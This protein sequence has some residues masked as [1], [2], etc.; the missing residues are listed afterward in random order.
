[1]KKEDNNF[2]SKPVKVFHGQ[3]LPE[4]AIP[5]GYLALIHAY[6]LNVPR[7]YIL[8]ATGKFHKEFEGNGWHIL[9]PRY[10]PVP[11]LEGH[12]VFALKYEGLNLAILKRLFETVSSSRIKAIVK[13]KPTG[14]YARRIWFL[15]EWL[16]GRKLG[17][18]D[19][20][21]G[22]YVPAVDP[23][24]QYCLD[25]K[26]SA[27]HRVKNNLPGTPN[28]CPLVFKTERIKKFVS[29]KLSRRAREIINDI[30]A[31]LLARSASFFLLE[32][33]RSS[34]VIEGETPPATRIQRWARVIGE[35][36]KRELDVD[37]LIRLQT[38]LIGDTRFVKE[39]I[40]DKGGF[41]GEHDRRTRRPLPEHISAKAM[42]L[43]DLIK[44][45][46]SFNREAGKELD[47]VISAAVLAFGFLFIHPFEDG[48]GR[49]HRYLIH[50]TLAKREFNPP[51]MIFPISSTILDKIEDY[52]RVLQDYS[53]RLLSAIK[54]ESTSDGNVKVL[55][56]TAD[57]YRFFDCTPQVEFLYKCV[58]KTVKENLPDEIIF[59]KKYDRFC[60]RINRIVDMPD[61][62]LNLLF[63]F[64]RQNEGRLSK[65]ALGKEFS[66]LTQKETRQIED[67]YNEIFNNELF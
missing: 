1:M 10:A 13:K 14:G 54:W 6:N 25:G 24:L 15:Y 41:V 61:R 2:F 52:R 21:R 49:I 62:V 58:E 64:L 19:V 29:M 57:F 48:N 28:F 9:T 27:R 50:H 26:N 56:E 35:A 65:R 8:Y 23:D 11:T 51:G 43:P 31:D 5:A 42:D 60:E 36:G 32:D 3:R 55:N 4:E 46:L 30:P 66:K 18:D 59:L 53:K 37:E 63:H 33:S 45:I 12:L 67:A 7:P 17:L 40:R 38:N 34:Y 44:G 47:S 20:N 22:N 16:T 39:G